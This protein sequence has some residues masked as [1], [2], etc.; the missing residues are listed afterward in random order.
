M[1]IIEITRQAMDRHTKTSRTGKKV[2]IFH[3]EQQDIEN[4]IQEVIRRACT[5]YDANPDGIFVEIPP[6]D[7]DE[8][9]GGKIV[10][11]DPPDVLPMDMISDPVE[12]VDF[13]IGKCV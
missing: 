6:L 2:A 8:D 10:I 12:L 9:F 4:I 5:D 1:D 3:L 7:S 11:V 13:A